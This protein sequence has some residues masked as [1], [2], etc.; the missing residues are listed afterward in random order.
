MYE[1]KEVTIPIF[2]HGPLNLLLVTE[3]FVLLE[4]LAQLR[5]CF[6]TNILFEYPGIANYDF[7]STYDNPSPDDAAAYLSPD[8]NPIFW[9]AVKGED[10]IERWFEWTS[11][12]GG[13]HKGKT[14]TALGLGKTSSGRTTINSSLIMNVSVFSYFN[15]E[16]DHDFETVVATVSG[17]VKAI[18]SIPR[19]TMINPAPSQDVRDYVQKL[20]VDIG[21][22]ANHWVGTTRLGTDSALEG[23][24]PV[25]DLNAQVYGTKNLHIVDAGILNGIFTA[26]PQAGIVIAAEKVA[27]EIIRL[28]G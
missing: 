3:S 24:K 10:G 1:N 22:T 12:V 2:S 14:Y 21:R 18:S 17:V 15:D 7:N 4:Y 19:A 23:G 5:F 6:G 13:P 16:G 25:V 9:D 20:F 26:N 27:K 11:Y 8:I 28:H